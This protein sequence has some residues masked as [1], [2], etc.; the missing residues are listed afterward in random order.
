MPIFNGIDILTRSF[1]MKKSP[2][3]LSKFSNRENKEFQFNN[4]INQIYT[5]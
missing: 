2:V 1:D 4:S 3:S 5:D